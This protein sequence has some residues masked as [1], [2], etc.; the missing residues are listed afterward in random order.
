I[1]KTFRK[2]NATSKSISNNVTIPV[3]KQD[4][5]VTIPVLKQS[6]Q[7]LNKTGIFTN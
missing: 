5:D 4:M 1:P 3:L 7:D 2:N 6:R